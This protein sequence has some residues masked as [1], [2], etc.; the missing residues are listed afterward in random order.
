MSQNHR[1]KIEKPRGIGLCSALPQLRNIILIGVFSSTVLQ[2]FVVPQAFAV[3]TAPI[4]KNIVSNEHDAA[5]L[6]ANVKQKQQSLQEQRQV[7]NARVNE[8]VK[9]ESV[10]S[11]HIEFW[12]NV[13]EKF[14]FEGDHLSD[15]QERLI[16]SEQLIKHNEYQAAAAQLKKLDFEYSEVI[17]DFKAGEYLSE[18]KKAAQRAQMDLV[19]YR[20]MKYVQTIGPEEQQAKKYYDEA[21]ASV[22]AG[23]LTAGLEKWPLASVGY[24]EK[25]FAEVIA[26]FTKVGKEVKRKA[27]VRLRD[28]K[29]QV[30]NIISDHFVAIPAGEFVMGNPNGSGDEKP[31]HKVTVAEFKLGKSEIPFALWDLCVEVR[32]CPRKP[33]DEGWGR[34]QK[35][36]INISYYD[37]TQKFIPWL[38][39]MTGKNYRLPSEA[40]W[41][42][43][44]RAGSK[45]LYSWGG[46]IDCS[47]AQY[48]G[49]FGSEC[50]A[51]AK[52][53]KRETAPVMSFSPN[54][55]GLYDMSGNVWEWVA[56]CYR[57]DYENAPVDGSAVD[58]TQ[59]K[60]G[61]LRGGAW[62]S[63][64]NALTAS[65]RF[66]F[67]RNMRKN[68]YGA[69]LVEVE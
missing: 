33:A 59:C 5:K 25:A 62:N 69:R 12:Q 34:D 13:T 63:D 14:I 45:T 35:P 26:I 10:D 7:L 16:A 64:A 36:A 37:I 54:A 58:D 49:G 27:A 60:V 38:T 55:F 32:T 67:P 57:S 39:E 65:N 31:V 18:V 24:S 3:D 21:Q 51:N 48:D 29:N 20:E 1:E 40:E 68:N 8:T 47:H 6:L 22:I 50:S 28:I 11:T 19:M 53:N 15:M 30:N 17:E 23:D 9:D 2:H 44:A 61:V 41:E 56:D 4:N 42:Y 52:G 46:T 66:Y 43:A